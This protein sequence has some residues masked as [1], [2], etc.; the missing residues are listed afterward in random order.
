VAAPGPAARPGDPGSAERRSQRR[1]ITASRVTVERRR[2]PDR[3]AR[4][5]RPGTRIPARTRSTRPGI[6]AGPVLAVEHPC[7][8]RGE[9]GRSTRT[10]SRVRPRN[11]RARVLAAGRERPIGRRY[12]HPDLGGARRRP[13]DGRVDYSSRGGPGPSRAGRRR[14]FR[15]QRRPPHRAKGI[16]P[17]SRRAG[18]ITGI[19]GSGTRTTG[20]RT[21]GTRATGTGGRGR[22]R[23]TAGLRRP[24][25]VRA[26]RQHRAP[27]RGWFPRG[28]R[29]PG[30]A[31]SSW[32]H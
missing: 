1:G 28:D 22:T 10:D 2:L 14:A 6:P 19:F 16:L 11:I 13:A 18:D 32:P 23:Q 4:R 30:R 26:P 31:G 24:G 8:P 15:D 25:G 29:L 5:T 9:C 20:T 17:T 12:G 3:G 7:A 27:E 21:T